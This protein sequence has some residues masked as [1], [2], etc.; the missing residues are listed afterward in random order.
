MKHIIFGGFDYAVRYEMDQD[1][2]YNGID[3]FVDNNP[4][5]IGTTYLGKE[6]KH[7]S[8]LL[9]EDKEDIMILIGSI[10]YRTEIA[11]QLK[12]MGFE[13][14]NH[15]LWA[16][17]FCG[18][19]QCERL[20]QHIEWRDKSANADSLIVTEQEEY[21]LHRLQVAA[22]LVNWNQYTTLIDLGAANERLR[23]LIPGNV[24]YI[25]AD[26]IRYSDETILWDANQHEFPKIGSDVKSTCIFSIGNL[27]YCSDWKWYLRQV[28]ENCNCFIWGHDDFTRV[29]REFRRTHWTRYNALFD[30][31]VIIYMLKT[32][33]DLNEAI[34]FR[35]K[36][37]L[38]KFE[39]RG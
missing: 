2:I 37:T 13:E 32:G 31:E 10:V 30:H 28:A 34:D 26:Y 29:S 5:L 39:K 22:R 21:A 11:F 20:W 6:I 7:P 36:T 4:H 33:F 8:A 35:L 9:D 3:Y 18:D 14:N 38:Y 17:S 16:I 1:A 12:D 23:E 15:F 27:Q 24:R 25:P 19:D